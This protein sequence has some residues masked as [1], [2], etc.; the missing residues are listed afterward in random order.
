[1]EP[2]ASCYS[3]GE[4]QEMSEIWNGRFTEKS[5]DLM[6]EF[7]AS[8]DVDKLLAGYDIKGSIAYANA[9]YAASIVSKHE[10]DEICSGLNT[11]FNEIR[12]GI[13]KYSRG[14]EDIHMNIEVRLQELIGTAAKKLHTGR[15]RNEQVVLDEKLYLKSESQKLKDILLNF[16][17]VLVEKASANK[18]TIIPA[19]THLQPAQPILLAHYFLSY[20]FKTLRHIRRLNYFFEVM[21]E[22]PLGVG[23][24]SG[25]TYSLDRKAMAAELGFGDIT[26]NSIDT[27]S[28]RD[29]I[30]DFLYLSSIISI[31]LSNMSED[32]IIYSTQYFNMLELPD[33]FC[34]GSSLM[35]QKK[36]PDALELIRGRCARII[37]NLN[38]VQI[39][40]KG[41]PMT[42][43]KDLQEDKEPL[44]DSLSVVEQDIVIMTEIIRN[45]KIKKKNLRI[46]AKKGYMESTDVADYLVTKSV[47]FREAHH[48]VG[49]MVKYLIDR[50]ML[51]S[52]ATLN[53]Y[54][55]FSPLFN[56]D[57]FEF[58]NLENIVNRHN[59]IG[60][61]SKESVLKQIDRIKE[62]KEVLK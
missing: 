57:I 60:G 36:N 25:T 38:R 4:K 20:A 6:V 11:I 17:D 8:I 46:A 39:L 22:C 13:F 14:L 26:Q 45:M 56:D 41:L 49:E 33:A 15:S 51:F 58:I 23:A 2:A 32:F 30:L 48:I 61:T 28:A 62:I 50:N 35:P 37:S 44:F 53:E 24:V 19:F 10:C 5:N 18:D 29:F 55:S 54:R 42:Y 7:N 9:L 34:T 1:M 47:P 16:I 52:D 27:T 40:L 21:D 12:T 59:S 31:D 3:R 43:N